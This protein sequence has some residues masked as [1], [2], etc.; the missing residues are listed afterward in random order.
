MLAEGLRGLAA[1]PDLF[2]WNP[3]A[4]ERFS[5]EAKGKNG[6]IKPVMQKGSECSHVC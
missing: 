1:E 5:A 4:R 3:A 2:R 6:K